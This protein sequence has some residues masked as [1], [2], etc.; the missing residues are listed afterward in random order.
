MFCKTILHC[1]YLTLIPILSII[2]QSSI[3]PM[4]PI[5]FSH[6]LHILSIHSL[7]YCCWSLV[8]TNCLLLLRMST[9][10]LSV[11]SSRWRIASWRIMDIRFYSSILVSSSTQEESNPASIRVI[12]TIN[13]GLSSMSY[14][15]Y[16]P[17]SL[18]LIE[19]AWL[20][21]E[22]RIEAEISAARGIFWF[23]FKD[24]TEG[25]EVVDEA[26]E[27]AIGVKSRRDTWSDDYN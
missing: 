18:T 1:C 9:S 22:V 26:V 14:D 8:D 19:I 27:K 25:K 11:A 23:R 21:D 16:W 17:F 5:P 13:S 20:L 12:T 3:L 4:L 2:L 15:S 10:L 7:S 24:S 6:S